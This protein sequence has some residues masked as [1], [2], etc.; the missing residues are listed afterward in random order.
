MKYSIISSMYD[1]KQNKI[2]EK[3]TEVNEENEIVSE[4]ITE[5]PEENSEY[6][7]ENFL[8]PSHKIHIIDGVEYLVTPEGKQFA[9]W[10]LLE[11]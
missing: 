1:E 6:V 11:K 10:S 8:V 7:V 3:Q 2:I 4:E 9:I 5:T